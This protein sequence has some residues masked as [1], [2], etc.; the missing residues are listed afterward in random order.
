MRH[1]DLRET[2]FGTRN[3]AIT[4]NYWLRIINVAKT[5]EIKTIKFGLNYGGILY[6]WMNKKLYRLPYFN[7]KTKRSYDL[8]EIKQIGN[9]YL[10]SRNKVNLLTLKNKTIRI[11]YNLTVYVE[12]ECP[13]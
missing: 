11:D 10:I 7:A 4:Y 12:P 9:H 8:K 13:F 3:V 6:G 5:M 1:S 2:L